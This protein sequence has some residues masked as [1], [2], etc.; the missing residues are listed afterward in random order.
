[1]RLATDA[2]HQRLHRHSGFAAVQE[3]TIS[4]TDYTKLL[5]RLEG[6]YIAFEAV[7]RTGN[8][9]SDWLAQ[10]L[11]TMRGEHWPGNSAQRPIMPK[12]DG[13]HGVLGALYVVEGSALGGRG[14]ARG[15][16]HLLGSG[17]LNGRR[18]FEGRGSS[19]GPAWRDFVSRLEFFTKEPA[20]QAAAIDAAVSTFSVFETW[21]AGWRTADV[22]R[23]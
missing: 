3:G 22:S 23:N 2:A 4:R 5:V 20:A 8:D 16:D 15:L 18:F 1:M 12:L 6:F 17:Q 21:L 19:T 9:R 7:T 10:D 13:E 14:L 11:E